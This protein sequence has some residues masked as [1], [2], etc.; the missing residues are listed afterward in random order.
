[1]LQLEAAGAEQVALAQLE[2]SDGEVLRRFFY[3][4]S[5]ESIYRRFLSPLARPEQA[6]PERLLDLDHRDREAVAAVVDGEIVG[7]ARYFRGPDPAAAEIAVVV[8]DAWQ[9]RGLATRTLS[10]LAELARSAGIERFTVTMQADN[11]P[12]IGLLRR[13]NAGAHLVHSHGIYEGT[14]PLRPEVEQ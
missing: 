5:P 4:L 2:R 13:F 1:M 6:R 11:R 7:V 12:A 3:R 8:A 14:I 9:G 10:S